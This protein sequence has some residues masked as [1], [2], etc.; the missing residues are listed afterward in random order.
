MLV[1]CKTGSKGVDDVGQV[2]LQA[3]SRTSFFAK[4]PKRNERVTLGVL[5][6]VKRYS[7]KLQCRVSRDP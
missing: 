4:L 2:R 6:I 7:Q 1:L 3:T 5:V